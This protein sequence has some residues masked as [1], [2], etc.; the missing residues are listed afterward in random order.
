MAKKPGT[1]GV[2][3][4]PVVAFTKPT[5][6]ALYSF[7]FQALISLRLGMQAYS[8]LITLL[9]LFINLTNYG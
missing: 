1:S 5:S 6:P 9:L 4:G 3:P 7:R 8:Q 2:V